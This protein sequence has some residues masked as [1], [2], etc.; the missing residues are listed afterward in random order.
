MS[1][2]ITASDLAR[3]AAR[4]DRW[5]ASVVFGP[6]DWNRYDVRT[7]G[8]WLCHSSWS[9]RTRGNDSDFAYSNFPDALRAIL[10][11]TTNPDGT[12]CVDEQPTPTDTTTPAAERKVGRDDPRWFELFKGLLFAQCGCE[13]MEGCNKEM[14]VRMA[15][16]VADA[17]LAQLTGGAK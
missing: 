14:W 3:A 16:E 13:G 7:I 9:N 17:A 1:N 2:T 10:A 15:M 5:G 11:A 8:K 12:L 6:K 4:L